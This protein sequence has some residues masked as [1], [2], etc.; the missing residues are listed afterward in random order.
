MND[1]ELFNEYRTA[2]GWPLKVP[3]EACAQNRRAILERA[4]QFEDRSYV[5]RLLALIDEQE[6]S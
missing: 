1:E 3:T 4:H 6:E 5:D 2:I